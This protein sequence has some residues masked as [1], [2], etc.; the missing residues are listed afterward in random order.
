VERQLRMM[1]LMRRTLTVTAKKMK[2][3]M[4]S[5]RTGRPRLKKKKRTWKKRRSRETK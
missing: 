3:G 5:S 1:K 2:E 4:N